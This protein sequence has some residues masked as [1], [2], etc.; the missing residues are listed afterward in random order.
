MLNLFERDLAFLNDS[1]TKLDTFVD[2]ALHIST[3]THIDTSCACSS[4]SSRQPS[5]LSSPTNKLCSALWGELLAWSAPA[6]SGA[7]REP[8]LNPKI[9]SL[10]LLGDWLLPTPMPSARELRKWIG[11]VRLKMSWWHKENELL[12]NTDNYWLEIRYSQ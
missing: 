2:E 8:A 11:W 4:N 7:R 3:A 10:S 1:E 9:L 6:I 5:E 12:T